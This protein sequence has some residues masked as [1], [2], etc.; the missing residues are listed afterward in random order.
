MEETVAY[1][2]S[3]CSTRD[4]VFKPA[5][6]RGVKMAVISL[7]GGSVMAGREESHSIMRDFKKGVR[8]GTISVGTLLFGLPEARETELYNLHLEN[9]RVFEEKYNIK[10]EEN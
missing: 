8:N 1:L 9:I 10:D 2:Y 5:D 4:G 7:L 3:W 6:Y